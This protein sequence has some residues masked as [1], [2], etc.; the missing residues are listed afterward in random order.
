PFIAFPFLTDANHPFTHRGTANFYN[1]HKPPLGSTFGPFVIWASISLMF[2]IL[3]VTRGG[4]RGKLFLWTAA[5]QNLVFSRGFHSSSNSDGADLGDVA[6][7]VPKNRRGV[8]P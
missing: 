5:L 7:Q 3:L 1:R 8:L 4:T 2:Q 6:Q